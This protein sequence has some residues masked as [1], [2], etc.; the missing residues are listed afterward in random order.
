MQLPDRV[1]LGPEQ[2]DDVSDELQH[3]SAQQPILAFQTPQGTATSLPPEPETDRTAVGNAKLLDVVSD[4]NSNT[5][6]TMSWEDFCT[7][8]LCQ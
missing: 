1:G 4:C 3:G 2:R 8:V 7:V 5:L 6:L